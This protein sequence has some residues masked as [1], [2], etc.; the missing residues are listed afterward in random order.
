VGWAREL[1]GSAPLALRVYLD[2]PAGLPEEPAALRDAVLQFF[3]TRS[4]ATRRR[5]HQLLQVGRTSLII[6]ILFLAFSLALSSM[7]ERAVRGRLGGLL[8]EGFLIVGWVAMWRPLEIFLYE[9]WPIRADIRLAARL[10]VMPV[11]IYY[12]RGDSDAW[13]KDWPAVRTAQ[14][15]ITGSG[16]ER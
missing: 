13:R 5:L 10:G 4:E 7:L 1:P 2:R 16:L 9:W 11:Q 12:T 6:G 3:R 14:S 15:A 8:S